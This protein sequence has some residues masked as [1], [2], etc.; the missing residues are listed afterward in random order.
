MATYYC[1]PD[2]KPS[3]A[4]STTKGSYQDYG[5]SVTGNSIGEN[6]DFIDKAGET[7]GSINIG[8]LLDLLSV[9]GADTKPFFE[10]FDNSAFENVLTGLERIK[11]TKE[12]NEIIKIVKENVNELLEKRGESPATFSSNTKNQRFAESPFFA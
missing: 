5:Y 10:S 11:A 8:G 3:M 9:A 12:T 1:G 7:L 6:I 2:K 4:Q